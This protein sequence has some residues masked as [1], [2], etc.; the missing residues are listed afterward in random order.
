MKWKHPGHEY[1][2]VYENICRKKRYYIFGAGDY[3]RHLR[4][5]LEKEFDLIAFIDNSEK[6]QGTVIDGLSCIPFS[7]V[8]KNEEIGIIMSVSQM[9]RGDII[10]FR[11]AG[12]YGEIMASQYNCRPLPGSIA[13]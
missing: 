13:E 2:H 4:T 5:I 11:S 8:K 3:G 1:D 7:Q 10:V 6:K 9:Q 12:A